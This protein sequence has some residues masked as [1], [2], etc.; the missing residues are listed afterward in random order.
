MDIK[1]KDRIIFDACRT[2]VRF[3]E[4]KGVRQCLEIVGKGMEID[5]GLV[6]RTNEIPFLLE[7]RCS[8]DPFSKI[9][10]DRLMLDYSTNPENEFLNPFGRDGRLNVVYDADEENID[11]ITR[12][13]FNAIGA[14]AF[15]GCS[16]VIDNDYLGGM[17]FYRFDKYEWSELELDTIREVT[18]LVSFVVSRMKLNESLH[19]L[20]EQAN[21]N[22]SDADNAKTRFMTNITNEMN[23]FPERLK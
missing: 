15:V 9:R 12:D 4:C 19:Y 14:R 23:I 21:K 20:L 6:M 7:M 3:E 13:F 10:D 18:S 8:W 22:I 16:M 5:G 11:P 17:C 1:T 2:L